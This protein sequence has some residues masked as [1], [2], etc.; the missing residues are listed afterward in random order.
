MA[1]TPQSIDAGCPAYAVSLAERGRAG[2]LVIY[3][4]AGLSRAEP[5][6]LPSGVEVARR[7]YDRLRGA[8]PAIQTFNPA[9]LTAHRRC[10]RWYCRW[11]GR[12]AFH[13]RPSS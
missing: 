3:A 7:L 6:G 2:G 13:G 4:G 12:P 11:R 9:D 5:A 1:H 8:F 10:R